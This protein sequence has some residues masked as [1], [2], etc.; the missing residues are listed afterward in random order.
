[1]KLYVFIVFAYSNH[2]CHPFTIKKSIAT[3]DVKTNR[4]SKFKI[5]SINND[6]ESYFRK[7]GVD[8]MVSKYNEKEFESVSMNDKISSI[9]LIAGTTVGRFLI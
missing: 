4:L 5:N 9:S 6:D 1:M 3:N 8:A 7:Y 2:R